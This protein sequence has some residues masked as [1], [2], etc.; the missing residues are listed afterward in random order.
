MNIEKDSIIYKEIYDKHKKDAEN[1]IRTLNYL[2]ME[3]YCY[4]L[5]DNYRNKISRFINN[6]RD[7][8]KPHETELNRHLL[9]LLIEIEKMYKEV[10]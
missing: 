3:W 7:L 6:N 9:D 8:L 2:D 4:A 10:K 5:F 1:E